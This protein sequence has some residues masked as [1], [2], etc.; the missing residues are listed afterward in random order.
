MSAP[1]SAAL[2]PPALPVALPDDRPPRRPARVRVLYTRYPHWAGHSG[3]TQFA[4]WLDPRWAAATLHG[5]SDSDADLPLPPLGAERLRARLRAAVQRGGMEWY[6]LSDLAAELRALP[7]AVAGRVDVVHFL[8]GEH[9]AQYLPAV[10]RRL[11]SRGARWSPLRPA[12]TVATFHQPPELLDRLVDP[13]VVRL[14]DHVTVVGPSQL[15]WFRAHLPAERVELILHGIDT[16]YWT[17]GEAPGSPGSPGRPAGALRCVTVGHWMRDW[18]GVRAVAERL[19]DERGIE[20][21]VVTAQPTAVDDLPNVVRHRG[22]AD[23]VLRRLY[24]DAD[25]L[26]LPLVESTANNALLEGIACGL[27][28]VSTALESVRAYVPGGEAILVEGSD[29]ARLADALLALRA[30]PARRRTMGAQAR[31][32]AE[33]L[34]WPLVAPA[35]ARMY[36][37]LAEG[38]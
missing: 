29:P 25:V 18:A 35:Y 34:A 21:H 22:V 36:A 38:A 24:Q 31:A 17:P 6:K 7:G 16:T 30:D 13:R 3:I 9:S 19:A 23:D 12:R 28:V 14:F 11:G 37:R 33:S 5:A 15:D 32:R 20:F 2:A 26:F 27:P 1:P 8:E 4:R 10:L